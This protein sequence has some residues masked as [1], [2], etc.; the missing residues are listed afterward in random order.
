MM[1]ALSDST[2]AHTRRNR[3]RLTALTDCSGEVTQPVGGKQVPV[4][5]GY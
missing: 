4:E 2:I 1:G 3:V 5:V